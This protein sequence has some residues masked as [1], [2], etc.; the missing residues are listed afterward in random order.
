MDKIWDI[1]ERKFSDILHQ[2]LYNRGII[3]ANGDQEKVKRFINPDFNNDFHSVALLPGYKK[4]IDRIMVAISKSETI[5][6]YADYDADGIPGAALL[7]KTFSK[8]GIKTEVYIP[9]RE[10]GYG[11]NRTGLDYL[12]NK[13][14]KLIISVDL[15]IKEFEYSKYLKTRGIDLIITD[16]HIADKELPEAFSVV[17]PKVGNSKYPFR[18]LSGAGVVYKIIQGLSKEYP[19]V[20]DEKFL[21]W[22]LDLVTISTISDVVPLIDENRL[23]AKYGLL[24][25]RKSHNLGIRAIYKNAGI[26]PEKIDAYNVGFQIG[27]RINAPGRLDHATI[28]FELLVTEDLKES[29]VLAKKIEEKNQERQKSMELVMNDAISIVNKE[30]LL[31]NKILI[32]SSRKWSKGVI[33]PVA[34]NL[35]EKYHRPTILFKIEDDQYVG[36]ARS[37]S[38]CH[39]INAIK[40]VSDL[41]LSFGGHSGAAGVRVEKNTFKNFSEKL[42]KIANKDI[43]DKI[44]QPKINIDLELDKDKINTSVFKKIQSLEPFGL[45]NQKPI[46][47]TKKLKLISHRIVGKDQNHLQMNFSYGSKKIKGIVFNHDN[48]KI[49]KNSYL[50]DL[51][52]YPS[53]NFWNGKWWADLQIIDFK[54]SKENE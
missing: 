49:I 47:L 53:I 9:T 3:S 25:L 26:N 31:K 32:L 38:D 33:G 46:F 12:I 16:H 43:S 24:V 20:I 29:E 6:I 50:Y 4:A 13:K 5:G 30:N 28:S 17:N 10:L 51:V 34:S 18:E 35:V 22:N 23:I 14:C 19:E 8:L 36:S 11:F 48:Q 41:T 7:Y 40:Q 37:I 1:K 45:G 54:L 21:K 42:I 44:L 52:F 2:I 39:I 27:P 15:G